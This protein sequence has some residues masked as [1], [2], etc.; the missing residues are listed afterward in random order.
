MRFLPYSQLFNIKNSLGHEMKF[1]R[2][3]FIQLKAFEILHK[4]TYPWQQL[5]AS[6]QESHT[7]ISQDRSI[8]QFPFINTSQTL[9]LKGQVKLSK[10]QSCLRKFSYQ[11][12][13]GNNTLKS[14]IAFQ[15]RGK[16]GWI[17]H[18]P[19]RGYCPPWSPAMCT[20]LKPTRKTETTTH[21]RERHQY[22]PRGS[23]KDIQP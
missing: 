5:N 20:E 8:L 18:S 6:S 4:H 3:S 23:G 11:N 7:C 14:K 12:T 16:R 17:H 10:Q 2:K 1:R 21:S 22:S 19:V 9:I 15:V 13:R